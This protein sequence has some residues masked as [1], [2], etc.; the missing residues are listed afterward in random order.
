MVK[1]NKTLTQGRSFIRLKIQWVEN[2][3]NKKTNLRIKYQRGSDA[4]NRH[5]LNIMSRDVSIIT[6][7]EN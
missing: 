4:S 6:T 3:S 5:P 7:E 1:K 2:K